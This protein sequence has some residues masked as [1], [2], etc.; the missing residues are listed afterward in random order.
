[1]VNFQI[2]ILIIKKYSGFLG[3]VVVVDSFISFGILVLL[4]FIILL[5][6]PPCLGRV[7]SVF[8][9]NLEDQLFHFS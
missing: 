9:P 7:L 1:M 5:F 2:E 3:A 8:V 4:A 6:L